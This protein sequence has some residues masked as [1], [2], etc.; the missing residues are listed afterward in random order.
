[1]DGGQ[2]AVFCVFTLERGKDVIYEILSACGGLRMTF[3]IFMGTW[4]TEPLSD[5]IDP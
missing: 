2:C 3:F 4:N 1:M 5:K